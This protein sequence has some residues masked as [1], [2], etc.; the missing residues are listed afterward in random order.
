MTDYD[1][2]V[3]DNFD[4]KKTSPEELFNNLKSKKHTIT[5]KQLQQ[6][7]DNASI[8]AT[9][10]IK[11]GQ[12]DALEKL[13]FILETNDKEKKLIDMGINTFV[14]RDDIDF[15][16]DHNPDNEVHPVKVIE[17]SRYEREIPDEIVKVI[18]NTKSLFDQMY[19]VY[20]DY[21]GK[22]ERQEKATKAKDPILFGVFCNTSERVCIDRFYYLGDW[23][24]EYCDL[25]LEKMISYLNDK[26]IDAKHTI[27]TP[28]SLED[29]KATIA[30]Y[31]EN[32]RLSY[33]ISSV[34]LSPN[35]P[36]GVFSKVK[37]Y[38]TNIFI[39]KN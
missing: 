33:T 6:M 20:T 25:T 4:A 9:K 30:Q 14:Y 31:K 3:H 17:L 7:Y 26:G 16:I 32:S 27:Y 5:D 39:K 22:K 11:T 38:L 8:I 24:D 23:V 10:Y 36:V 35:K 13:V 21:T 18:E 1:P 2:I 29:L 37:T 12:K 34:Q 19:V 15:Y 28:T